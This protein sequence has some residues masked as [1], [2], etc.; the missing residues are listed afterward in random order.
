MLHEP[1]CPLLRHCCNPP[2]GERWWLYIL[3]QFLSNRT[4]PITHKVIFF[5]AGAGGG[6]GGGEI[7]VPVFTLRILG[8]KFLKLF[9]AFL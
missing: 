2:Y 8:L 3:P 5:G 9:C 1:C 6:G 7:S 4:R